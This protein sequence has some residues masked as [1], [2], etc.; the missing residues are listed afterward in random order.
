MD[1]LLSQKLFNMSLNLLS[2]E[3]LHAGLVAKKF[4]CREIIENCLKCI[5]EKD[6]EIHAFLSV[7]P[8]M[9]LK[10]ADE[11][12]S[13]IKAGKTIGLLEGIPFSVK[14]VILVEDMSATAGSKILESFV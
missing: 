8:E 11:V 12:D 3:E 4:S 9:A 7:Y 6:E 14:D 5:K 1:T 2:I 10:R 13:K